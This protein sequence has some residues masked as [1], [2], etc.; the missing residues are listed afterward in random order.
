MAYAV[1]A[2]VQIAREETLAI[3]QF[4]DYI[5]ETLVPMLMTCAY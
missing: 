4:E 1:T 2:Y 5:H 3:Q